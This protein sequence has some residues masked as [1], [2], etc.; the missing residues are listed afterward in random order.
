MSTFLD[1]SGLRP[2]QL[3]AQCL[4]FGAALIFSLTSCSD[5]A[6]LTA[7]EQPT[8]L[9]GGDDG[10]GG[11]SAGGS[12]TST[13]GGTSPT[14]GDS[15]PSGGSGTSIAGS[16]GTGGSPTGGGDRSGGE[17]ETACGSA[18]CT[19]GEVC[20][21]VGASATCGGSDCD[22]I[23]V[24]DGA[25]DCSAGV[26]YIKIAMI[27]GAIRESFCNDGRAGND[28]EVGC[29]GINNCP[30]TTLCCG[31]GSPTELTGTSCQSSCGGD[32]TMCTS[33]DECES[34]RCSPLSFYPA[35]S[36]CL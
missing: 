3:S 6:E 12:G 29:S 22:Y 9:G 17:G 23:A 32:M 7:A 4:G 26:C 27:G 33:D 16:S 2:V 25:E 1:L 10:S 11:T 19:R 18:V 21:V 28:I 15:G 14:G 36:S 5:A 34:G 24:C 20:C 8:G 13:G 35:L 30:G 31:G